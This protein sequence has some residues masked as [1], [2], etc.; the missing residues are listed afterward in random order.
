VLYETEDFCI[1]GKRLP[2]VVDEQA[3]QGI[4]IA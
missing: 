4:F 1:E 2:L 3:R